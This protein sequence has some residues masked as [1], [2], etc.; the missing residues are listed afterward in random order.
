MGSVVADSANNAL[1]INGT[2]VH[3][4][5]ANSPEEIDYTKYDIDN[6]LV[7]DNTGA[8]TTQ[9]ALARHLTSKGVEKFYL[10]LLEKECL[11]LYMV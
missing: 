10:L 8:F 4:I 7:I 5:T 6:A 3:I 9:E 1:I 11:T 2:T